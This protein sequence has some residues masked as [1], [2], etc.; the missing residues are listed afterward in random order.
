MELPEAVRKVTSQAAAVVGWGGVLGEVRVG[1]PADLV[2]FDPDQIADRA[3]FESPWE[4]P[5]GID[6]V[7][8]AGWRMVDGGDLTIDADVV[9]GEPPT[10]LRGAP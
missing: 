1:L 7:W 6:G 2:L 10:S 5:V 3:T 8:I 9:A 4:Y